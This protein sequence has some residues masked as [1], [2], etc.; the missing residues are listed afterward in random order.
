M[1]N[2]IQNNPYRFLGVTS[3]ATTKEI[4]ANSSRIKAFCNVGKHVE[5]P[6]DMDAFLPKMER[7]MESL[8]TASSA[9]ELP[10]D[11]LRHAFF[12]F[13]NASNTDTEAIECLKKGDL[14]QAMS[15][16]YRNQ[17]F[18]NIVNCGIIY[19]VKGDYENA[20]QCLLKVIHDNE[21][22]NSFVHSVCGSH[23]E[24]P[25]EKVSQIFLGELCKEIPLYDLFKSLQ[26]I[27]A[28]FEK[29]QVGNMI[30]EYAE[31]ELGK[32]VQN[33][34]T[35]SIEDNVGIVKKTYPY[36][37]AIE[38][39]EG[40]DGFKHQ[41][42][43]TKVESTVL[44]GLIGIVNNAVERVNREGQMSYFSSPLIAL[45]GTIKEAAR[46]MHHLQTMH[47]DSV[48]QQRLNEQ[49]HTLGSLASK[50]GDYSLYDFCVGKRYHSDLV[51]V[52]E[53]DCYHRCMT[54]KDY[55]HYLEEFPNGLYKKQAQA[56]F[57]EGKSKR[58]QKAKEALAN[59]NQLDDNLYSVKSL[60]E[61]MGL[62]EQLD[63][64]CFS[65]CATKPD[66]RL[67]LNVFGSNAKHKKEAE[68]V[69]RHEIRKQ[70]AKTFVKKNIAWVIVTAL[71]L[72]IIL[73]VGVNN[74]ARGLS[75]LFKVLAW[76]FGIAAF[77]TLLLDVKKKGLVFL[78][79]IA[80]VGGCLFGFTRLRDVADLQEEMRKMEMCYG[81]LVK[82][83]SEE[84]C[85]TFLREHPNSSYEDEVLNIYYGLVE[86]EGVKALCSF[87]S[88]YNSSQQGKKALE[89]AKQLSDSLY[90]VANKTGTIEGW[91]S[92]RQS[93]P[94]E[95]YGDSKAKIDSIYN[96]KWS[97][98]PKAWQEASNM[99]SRK[100]FE[101]YLK[102]YPKGKHKTQAEKH[103]IDMDV[104]SIFAGNTKTLPGLDKNPWTWTSGNNSTVTIDN[105]FSGSMTMLFSGA[106][107]S[108]K[109]EIPAKGKSQ[110]ITL[111]NGSYRIT[112]SISGNDTYVG[113]EKL[114]GGDYYASYTYSYKNSYK[115][116]YNYK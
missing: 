59:C 91:N 93:V 25:M 18:S 1:I 50:V 13:M 116:K 16:L 97:T 6:M 99:G 57:E 82:S 54:Y 72:L 43:S 83:P 102:M 24:F 3:N 103:L 66:F 30:I 89:R 8:E 51:L 28:D 56:A 21:Y 105:N 95:Y 84:Q 80:L 90:Q 107:V 70:K 100:A 20:I 68:Y 104:D 45:K 64:K 60:C 115:D 35:T 49:L 5:Y 12:W 109:V 19:W 63:E 87:A 85:R 76:C 79:F 96:S 27:G 29:E 48:A 92:Y 47:L 41:S 75:D 36:L 65:L 40:K 7:T 78:L 17:N 53:W 44:N 39:V 23:V 81:K 114:T 86:K 31:N 101:K 113:T 33:E 110:K 14:E 88:E 34:K 74:G 106:S 38:E 98:E 71:I 22:R 111:P 32:A 4:L 94:S 67:Y 9:L 69:L 62:L 15:V 2:L 108:K 112:L 55:Q 26:K 37:A 10:E 42:W 61:E 46:L 73:A 58:E 77:V 11:K 52:T